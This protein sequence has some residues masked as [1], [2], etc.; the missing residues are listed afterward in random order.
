MLSEHAILWERANSGRRQPDPNACRPT[1]AQAAC[2]GTGGLGERRRRECSHP[3]T[4]GG[5]Q[6]QEESCDHALH[7]VQQ[8]KVEGEWIAMRE[9]KGGDVD[10]A[11]ESAAHR[12]V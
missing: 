1:T 9:S 8:A 7:G 5:H 12:A 2:T 10:A 3:P 6:G 11:E 4:C